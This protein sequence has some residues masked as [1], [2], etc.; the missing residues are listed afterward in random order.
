MH[1]AHQWVVV[2]VEREHGVALV[3]FACRLVRPGAPQAGQAPRIAVG[4]AKL[5]PLVLPAFPVR[6]VEAGRRDDAALPALPGI[7]ECGLGRQFLGPRVVRA[8]G[9]LGGL[10][11]P[12]DPN[13]TDLRSMD[14]VW[15]ICQ[16]VTEKPG[17][18]RVNQL[19]AFVD[20]AAFT[21]TSDLASG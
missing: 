12:R 19:P 17:N 15:T 4:A 9:Q 13:R 5:P 2:G 20:C 21:M 3:H 11:E 10:G 1:P 7:L 14:L 8:E 18:P 6:L 16:G